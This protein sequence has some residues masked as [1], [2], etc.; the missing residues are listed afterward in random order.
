MKRTFLIIL[1]AVVT[2]YAVNAQDF[3]SKKGTPILPEKGD[4]SFSIDA[5][6]FFVYIGNMFHGTAPT[7]A[8]TFDF[9]GLNDVPMWTLQVKKFVSPTMAMRARIRL[10]FSSQTYKNTILDQTNTSTT[11]AYVDDKWTE[12]RMNIVLG[13]GIEKRR[14]KGRV[15]GVYGAMANI[16]VGTHGNSI[17]Y[18]NEMSTVYTN[19]LST[20]YPWTPSY[21]GTGYIA[22]N[23]GNRTLKDNDGMTFGIG[24][25]GFL[26]VE[27]FFAPKMSIGGEFTWG[28]M[29]QVTGKGKSEV[30]YLNGAPV[31]TETTETTKSGGALYFGVDNGNTGGASNLSFYF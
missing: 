20:D 24:V 27:Y 28:L 14:G 19:P 18:G 31:V 22:S 21:T 11:P 29:L 1:M 26:G 13:A 10:G 4:Y 8:P 9:P 12:T 2:V 6:P 3:T 7:D 30:E 5:V 25:N 23:T 16:M 17:T 15:Q